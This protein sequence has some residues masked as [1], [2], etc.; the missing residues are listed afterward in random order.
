MPQGV[1]V[2]TMLKSVRVK[3]LGDTNKRQ[4][5]QTGD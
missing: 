3:V 2:E 5:P 1:E 4:M